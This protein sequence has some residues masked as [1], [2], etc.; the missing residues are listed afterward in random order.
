MKA[1][2]R[3]LLS[4]LDDTVRWTGI[5]ARVADEM[6]DAPSVDRKHR[7]LRWMPIWPIAF[8]CALFVFSLTWP[9]ALHPVWLGGVNV[10]IQAC[11]L[12]LVMGF[13]MHGPWKTVACRR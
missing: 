9:S 12:A 5:P 3:S 11:Q 7:P 2:H 1:S 13:H 8:S 6:S 10:G 4:R